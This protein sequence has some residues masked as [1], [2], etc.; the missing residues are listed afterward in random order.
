LFIKILGLLQ[1]NDGYVLKPLQSAPR[2][3]RELG[4][5]IRIFSNDE[6]NLNEDERELR[7]LLPTFRGLFTH[8]ESNLISL[9]TFF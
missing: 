6:F 5:F 3:E 7:K 4:F 9:K 1:T 8:N 2:G